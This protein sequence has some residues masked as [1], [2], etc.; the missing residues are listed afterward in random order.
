[1]IESDKDENLANMTCISSFTQP[2]QIELE[3]R[4]QEASASNAAS[5]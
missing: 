3:T 2:F 5:R 1:M 4:D